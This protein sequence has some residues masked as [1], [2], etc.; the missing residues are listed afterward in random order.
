M[1]KCQKVKSTQLETQVLQ[2]LI[3]KCQILIVKITVILSFRRFCRLQTSALRTLRALVPAYCLL[4]I[5][6]LFAQSSWN[7]LRMLGGMIPSGGIRPS[8]EN[9]ISITAFAN[10]VWN[11]IVGSK[12][13]KN[14]ISFILNNTFS[15]PFS[16]FM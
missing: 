2:Y 14:H 6:P 15:P 16:Q 1:Q 7:V 3:L 12:Q 5:S 11:M 9:W 4:M 13:V 8:F 10:A